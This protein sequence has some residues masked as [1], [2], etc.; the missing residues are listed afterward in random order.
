M[1]FNVNSIEV[2]VWCRR[3]AAVVSFSAARILAGRVNRRVDPRVITFIYIL[4]VIYSYMYGCMF[5]N[6]LLLWSTRSTPE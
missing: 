6:I 3:F 2:Y 4:A 1:Q 5:K